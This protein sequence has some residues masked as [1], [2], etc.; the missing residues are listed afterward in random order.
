LGIIARNPAKRAGKNVLPAADLI[1]AW[2]YLLDCLL[3]GHIELGL[4]NLS[5]HDPEVALAARYHDDIAVIVLSLSPTF[6]N[7]AAVRAMVEQQRGMRI[8]SELIPRV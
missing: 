6:D 7:E 1:P 2:E 4:I 3:G 8:P 5:T